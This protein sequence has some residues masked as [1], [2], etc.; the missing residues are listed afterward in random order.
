MQSR[1]RCVQC[2]RTYPVAESDVRCP[3]CEAGICG[4]CL[5]EWDGEE[6]IVCGFCDE[7]FPP[8][9]RS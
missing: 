1:K 5:D 4:D 2:L 8:P 6:E 7:E 3:R 9:G